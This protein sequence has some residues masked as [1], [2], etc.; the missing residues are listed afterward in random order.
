MSCS[1]KSFN[2]FSSVWFFKIMRRRRNHP[3]IISKLLVYGFEKVF[4]V[5]FLSVLTLSRNSLYSL[6]LT[7]LTSFSEEYCLEE[8]SVQCDSSTGR[9]WLLCCCA[10]VTIFIFHHQLHNTDPAPPPPPLVKLQQNIMIPILSTVVSQHLTQ[11]IVYIRDVSISLKIHLWSA[12]NLIFRWTGGTNQCCN[13]SFNFVTK[14]RNPSKLLQKNILYFYR[15]KSKFICF[16]PGWRSEGDGI[17]KSKIILW[18]WFC[19]CL[20]CSDLCWH[21]WRNSRN[22]WISS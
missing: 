16:A 15:T 17:W 21:E 2:N 6:M 19:S 9:T 22:N 18:K 14:H 4:Q 5:I 12:V 8:R 10:L 20:Q 11:C 13:I 7:F 1:R 3:Q